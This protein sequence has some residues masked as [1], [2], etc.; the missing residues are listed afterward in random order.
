MM[1]KNKKV[2]TIEKTGPPTKS[3]ELQKHVGQRVCCDICQKQVVFSQKWLMTGERTTTGWKNKRAI[4]PDCQP[5]VAKTG[6][7][8]VTI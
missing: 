8:M 1:V 3:E 4:C 2:T 6:V 7:V 5:V